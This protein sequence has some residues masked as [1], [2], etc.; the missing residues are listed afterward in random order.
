MEAIIAV[1]V[2][3]TNAHGQNTTKIVTDLIISK[4]NKYV[5][6]AA[7]KAITTISVAH[8]SAWRTTLEFSGDEDSTNLTNF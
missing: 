1:G 5:N 4:V 8:L 7:V 3:R 6:T 2:A